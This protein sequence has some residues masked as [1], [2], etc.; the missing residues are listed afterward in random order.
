MFYDVWNQQ[1]KG[2]NEIRRM[3][4]TPVVRLFFTYYRIPWGMDWRFYGMPII[5]KHRES[6]MRFGDHLQLRSTV[7]SNPLGANHPVILST[8]RPGASLI[9]GDHFG[10]TGGCLCA[11]TKISIG[12][13]VAIGANTIVADTDFHSLNIESRLEHSSDGRSEP[14]TIG[15]NAFIGMNCLILKGVSIGRGAVIGA[16][17][18][19]AGE[20]EGGVIAHGNPAKVQGRV[21]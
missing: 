8:R 15:D 10:M 17:S 7:K 20:I 1:W 2:G 5:Q 3:L 6:E 12:N 9:I 14:V 11:D 18:V 16:G 13:N 4:I 21:E 19:V